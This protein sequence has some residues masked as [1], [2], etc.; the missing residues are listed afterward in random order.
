M[1][2]REKLR[3]KLKFIAMYG[4]VCACCGQ[5]DPRFLTLDHIKNDGGEH[6]KKMSNHQIYCD[7]TSN[8]QPERYQLLCYNCNM[9]RHFNIGI[10]GIGVCPHKDKTKDEWILEVGWMLVN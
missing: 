3:R 8:Y 7:A 2:L 5:D 9:A 10:D 1:N 6:R 4:K